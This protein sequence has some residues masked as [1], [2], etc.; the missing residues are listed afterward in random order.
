MDVTDSAPAMAARTASTPS[1]ISS[2][3]R[4]NPRSA[5]SSTTPSAKP[6]AYQADGT[7]PDWEAL[8]QT[9]AAT[10]EAVR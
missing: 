4:M 10:R 7:M 5:P 2:K 8:T 6:A 9:M 1:A 3:P